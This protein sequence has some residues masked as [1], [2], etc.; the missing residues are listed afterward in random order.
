MDKKASER[1]I[2][3]AILL[4]LGSRP[5]V[6]IMRRN[7][8]KFL[9]VSGG[10]MTLAVRVLASYGI[11]ASVV[12]VGMNG[13]ADLQGVVGN[14]KCRQ[15][16]ADTHPRPFAIEVKSAT[17]RQSR[18]Q[19]QWQRGVW[20]RRGAKYILARSVEGARAAVEGE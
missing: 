4:D 15:C 14:Q 16:G 8:G 10:D 3:Q 1:E 6:L 19:A 18:E 5:E 17:G 2:Q 11:R 20:E 12:R 7:V 13:E 9:T